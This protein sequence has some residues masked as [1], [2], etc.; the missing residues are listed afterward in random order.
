ME[1]FARETTTVSI[2][3]G[4]QKQEYSSSLIGDSLD[5]RTLRLIEGPVIKANLTSWRNHPMTNNHYC[6]QRGVL[7]SF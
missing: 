2:H 6:M 4:T 3:I 7:G 5:L 1:L